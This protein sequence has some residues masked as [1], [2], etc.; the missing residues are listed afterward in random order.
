M[1]LH[2]HFLEQC[3]APLGIVRS[4]RGF[5][6]AQVHPE[7]PVRVYSAG[8]AAESSE[9]AAVEAVLEDIRRERD[10]AEV[11][12]LLWE[13]P[14]REVLRIAL[15]AAGL[16]PRVEC[17]TMSA[18]LH[19][20]ER[21]EAW[22]TE[23]RASARGEFEVRP[24][25]SVAEADEWV[26]IYCE[27]NEYDEATTSGFLEALPEAWRRRTDSEWYLG[28]RDE[29]AVTCAKLRFEPPAA[30]EACHGGERYG[31]EAR[32][33]GCERYAGVYQLATRHADRGRGYAGAVMFDLMT[34]AAERGCSR[35]LL[36]AEPEARR[37]Y[38]R[39]GFTVDGV[40]V[41]YDLKG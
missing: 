15:D 21:S 24:V 34:R 27:G 8:A 13:P 31:D 28:Y 14:R 40:L 39:L 36:Q 25:S 35:V 30:G 38:E 17:P 19:G 22:Q 41:V 12:W 7:L 2:H 5:T 33:A 4:L 26:R 1:S 9:P 3:H 16:S 6:W 23:V 37:L 10:P 11:R 32:S 20:T 18:P 29:R